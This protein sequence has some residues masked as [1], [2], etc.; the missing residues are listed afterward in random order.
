MEEDLTPAESRIREVDTAKEMLALT[1]VSI[2]ML[3]KQYV[4]GLHMQQ[5]QNLLQ[6]LN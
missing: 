6:L 4:L 2:L 1:K 5:S 3:A